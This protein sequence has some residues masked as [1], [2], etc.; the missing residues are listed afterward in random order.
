V[1]VAFYGT[2]HKGDSTNNAGPWDVYVT[3][4][5]DFLSKHPHLEQAKVS[6]HPSHTNPICLSGLGC[7]AGSAEDRNLGDFFQLD[8]DPTDGSVIVIWADTANQYGA[9]AGSAV[10]SYARQVSGPSLLKS[11][12]VR[13]GGFVKARNSVSD[14][15][16]D[17]RLYAEG[18]SNP[19][20]DILKASVKPSGDNLI[21]TVKLKGS[22][23]TQMLDPTQGPSASIVVSWWAG[24]KNG[25]NGDLGVVRFV[26]MTTSGA[27][28]AFFGGEPTYLNSSSGTSRFA[29]F[30]AGPKAL[31][32]TGSFDGGTVSWT[33]SKAAAGLGGSFQPNKLF[34]VTARTLQGYPFYVHNAGA[35]Q[36]DAS[37]PFTYDKG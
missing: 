2:K 14:A 28:Q 6:E 36:V 23:L 25:D 8:M 29:E 34:S 11:K 35:H 20:M 21:I 19:S 16:G 4:S 7:T 9:L 33:I 10:N 1:A 31:P 17:A 22:S 18:V 13:G 15:K 12:K 24:Q 37:Q 5:T 30:V 27:E 32:V 26:G 3:Q